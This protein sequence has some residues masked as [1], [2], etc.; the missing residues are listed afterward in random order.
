MSR[1]KVTDMNEEGVGE[2]EDEGVSEE[3]LVKTSHSRSTQ[4]YFMTWEAQ[5]TVES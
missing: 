5:R 2:S 1:D 4:K 3:M